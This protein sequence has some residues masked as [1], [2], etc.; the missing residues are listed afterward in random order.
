MVR[1]VAEELAGRRRCYRVGDLE[2]VLQGSVVLI[3]GRPVGLTERERAVLA[4]LVEQ[5]GATISRRVLLRQVWKDPTVDPHVL[6][7]TVGRL[8][9]KLGPSGAALETAVRRGYRLR[10]RVDE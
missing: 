9:S 2:M 6:E 5:P 10:A 1:L 4:K 7:T 3:D 8:R